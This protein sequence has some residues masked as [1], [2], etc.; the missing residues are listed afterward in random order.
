[1]AVSDF[2]IGTLRAEE[3]GDADAL[4]REAGWNQIEA[5]WRIFLELG[6]VYAVRDK[7]RVI[8]T[9][10][11]LPYGGRFAWISMVL[12]AGYYRRQ[13]LGT[14]LVQHCVRDLTGKGLVPV[15]DATRPGATSISV[16]VSGIPSATVG[17]S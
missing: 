16:S 10:A 8:A 6:T 9:A 3:L 7:G 12:I 15:L 13:G 17:C 11:V 2:E 1:M 5:D 4:V 14:R